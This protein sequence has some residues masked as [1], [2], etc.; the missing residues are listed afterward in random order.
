M[1]SAISVNTE[2]AQVSENKRSDF[3]DVFGARV[4]PVSLAPRRPPVRLK[5]NEQ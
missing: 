3:E 2:R 1:N 4:A 5:Q